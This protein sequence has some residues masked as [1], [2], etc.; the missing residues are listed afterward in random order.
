[1]GPGVLSADLPQAALIVLF[2]PRNPPVLLV[3]AATALF[4]LLRE[5][6]WRAE[7]SEPIVFTL[8]HLIQQ[9]FGVGGWGGW[10]AST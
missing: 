9:F 6:V 8:E 5:R 7:T 1:M 10:S 4:A 2:M 3:N